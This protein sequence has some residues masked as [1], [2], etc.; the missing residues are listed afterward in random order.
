MTRSLNVTLNTTEQHLIVRSG[1][2]EASVSVAAGFGRHGMPL[3]ASN[4]A[5]TAFYF[6]NYEEAETR[7][8]DDVSL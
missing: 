3:P 8:T 7:R 6:P 4:D 2:L 5:G 1:K